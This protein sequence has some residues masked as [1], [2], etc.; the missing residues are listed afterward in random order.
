MVRDVK[1]EKFL[2]PS[3]RDGM[4]SW[5]IDPFSVCTRVFE[6]RDETSQAEGRRVNLRLRELTFTF[7]PNPLAA[8][9]PVREHLP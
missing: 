2:V 6:T 1:I 4:L 9:R 5:V 7:D 3:D 8:Q